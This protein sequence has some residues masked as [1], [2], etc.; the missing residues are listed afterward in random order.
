MKKVL[1][2][3]LVLLSV[4]ILVGCGNKIEVSVGDTNVK[5]DKTDKLKSISFI[6]PSN[7]SIMKDKNYYIIDYRKNNSFVFREAINYYENQSIE[8]VIKEKNLLDTGKKEINNIEWYL[9]AGSTQ[10]GESC[11]YYA[12]EY[13]KDTYLI[14]FISNKN[15]DSFIKE[16]MNKIEFK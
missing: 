10:N 13:N 4:F 1:S 6:Y 11:Y 12:Y 14:T 3:L 2:T 15:M 8:E 5:L 16:V 9:Y 7:T